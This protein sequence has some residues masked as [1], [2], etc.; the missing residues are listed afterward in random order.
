MLVKEIDRGACD[1]CG[2]C[3]RICA[4]S[5]VINM[6]DD[7]YPRFERDSACIH[8][9]HCLAVCP[10]NAIRFELTGDAGSGSYVAPARDFEAGSDGPEY[11]L[12]ALDATRSCRFF[13]GRAVE[14][15]KLERILETMV[16]APSS[17]NEQ[18]R[19]FYVFDAKGKVDALDADVAASFR[20]TNAALTNP[21][22]MRLT[23]AA[24]AGKDYSRVWMRNRAMAD[25]PKAERK[26]IAEL[27]FRDLAE[28]DA[29]PGTRYFF[30]STAAFVVTSRTNTLSMHGSFYKADVEIAVTHGVLAA[31]A[32]GL[33]SC[34]MG[35][36][37]IAF[38]RDKALRAKYGIPA[39]ER[40]DGI[41]ALGYSDLGWERLPPRGPVKVAWL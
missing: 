13:D 32:L 14:R 27:L 35:L 3:A 18:N 22:A 16:R 9:G 41:L 4:N 5:R 2:K 7:G 36:A 39:N 38:G 40:V 28:R 26:R 33:A 23:A 10:R 31:A 24:L 6:G 20:R 30:H 34:R 25:M 29:D 19:N 11:L 1:K 8:C 21:L 37:E 17:G 12:R 15:A